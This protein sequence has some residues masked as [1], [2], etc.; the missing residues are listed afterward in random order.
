MNVDERKAELMQVFNNSTNGTV[1]KKLIDETVFLEVRMCELEKLPFIRC[2]PDD[3]Y[4]QKTTPAGRMYTQLSAQ[5][6]AVL[7]NLYSLSGKNDLSNEESPVRQWFKSR[8]EK[9]G[10]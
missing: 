4:K 10:K 2:H 3:P 6:N 8:G 7:R 1:V 9:N 5:Y